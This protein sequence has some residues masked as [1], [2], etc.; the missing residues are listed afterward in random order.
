M[1]QQLIDDLKATRQTL[2]DRGRCQVWLTTVD[3]TVCLDG[4]IG[5]ALIPG[6]EEVDRRFTCRFGGEQDPY[7]LLKK[8]PRAMDVMVALAEQVGHWDCLTGIDETVAEVAGGDP[9]KACWVFNDLTEAGDADIFDAIDK[10]I[11]E[12]GGMA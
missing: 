8:S 9:T 5:V 7:H 12:A 4:A 11:V 3:G 10:A 6:F 1:N 2:A